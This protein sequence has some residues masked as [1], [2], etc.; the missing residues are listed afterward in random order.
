MDTPDNGRGC[1]V[2]R[3]VADMDASWEPGADVVR[4]T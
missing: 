2:S 1:V 3:C 4:Y